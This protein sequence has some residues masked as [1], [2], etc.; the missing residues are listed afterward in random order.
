MSSCLFQGYSVKSTEQTRPEFELALSIPFF[1]ADNHYA[2][3][4][5]NWIKI[6]YSNE[7]ISCPECCQKFSILITA[8]N[9]CIRLHNQ[10]WHFLRRQNQACA[11]IY[12]SSILICD[13]KYDTETQ[14]MPSKSQKKEFKKPHHSKHCYAWSDEAVS[15][16]STCDGRKL[17]KTQKAF[18]F[19]YGRIACLEQK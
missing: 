7:A 10:Y 14:T 17:R 3:H 18:I 4:I 16:F 8:L 5:F 2:T 12:L 15:I 19:L 13:R 9:L 11:E 1:S 6:I